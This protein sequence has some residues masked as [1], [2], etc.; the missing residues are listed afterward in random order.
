MNIL[1]LKKID[2]PKLMHKAVQ[3]EPVGFMA[4]SAENLT[5]LDIDDD[6]IHALFPLLTDKQARVPDYF[7]ENLIGAHISVIYPEENTI[8]MPNDLEKAHRFSIKGVYTAELELELKMYYFLLIESPSLVAL[9]KKYGLASRP[10]FKSHL[11]EF[12]I[13]VGVLLK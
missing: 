1:H 6:Y 5:Y 2:L 13:T 7:S 9:R 10:C 4:R 8:I 11:V 3:L 12:H